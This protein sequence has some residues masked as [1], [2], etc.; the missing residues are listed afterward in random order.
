VII[1][2]PKEDGHQGQGGEDGVS[3]GERDHSSAGEEPGS[4]VT[5]GHI[6]SVSVGQFKSKAH[7]ADEGE[8]QDAESY[9]ESLRRIHLLQGLLIFD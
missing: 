3:E 8:Q 1:A 5:G 6:Q 9:I 4:R 2:N 7:K